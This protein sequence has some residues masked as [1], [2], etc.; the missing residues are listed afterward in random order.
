MTGM[1]CPV[2]VVKPDVLE[3]CFTSII[4]VTRI[5]EL[6]MLELTSNRSIPNVSSQ[7]ASVTS[8]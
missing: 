7:H 1:L 2:P 6:G 4:R 8:Y 5:G 3:E